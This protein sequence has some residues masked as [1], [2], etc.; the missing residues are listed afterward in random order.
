MLY[1]NT[2]TRNASAVLQFY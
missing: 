1:H 2:T